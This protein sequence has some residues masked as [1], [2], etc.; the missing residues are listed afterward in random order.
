MQSSRGFFSSISIFVLPDDWR[1]DWHAVDDDL[2]QLQLFRSN[3]N[4]H[5]R[6]DQIIMFA[7]KIRFVSCV[8]LSTCCS[9]ANEMKWKN[10]ITETNFKFLQFFRKFSGSENILNYVF[11]QSRPIRLEEGFILI[12]QTDEE[13][14]LKRR[15]WNWFIR[16]RSLD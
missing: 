6:W 13:A 3:L 10:A 9:R 7:I 8:T 2:Q 1:V 15:S 5:R 4:N 16:F 12:H 11:S 14:Q